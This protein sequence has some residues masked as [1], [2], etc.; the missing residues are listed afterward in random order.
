MAKTIDS[1]VLAALHLLS[2]DKREEG[3]L[4]IE[5]VK[6]N[7]MNGALDLM[8]KGYATREIIRKD[9]AYY[10]LTDK[11]TQFLAEVINYASDQF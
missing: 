3:I 4:Y 7:I 8:D 11:G 6:Q 10:H 5:F 1:E 2:T 9:G